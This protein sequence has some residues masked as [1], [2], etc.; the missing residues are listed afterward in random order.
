MSPKVL[1]A[2]SPHVR[3]NYVPPAELDRLNAF[4]NC[5]W[6]SCE[7]G[8]IYDTN[9]DPEAAAQLRQRVADVEALVICHGSPTITAA[10][11]DAAPNLKFIGELEGDRFATRIDLDAAWERGI[12]TVDVTN[13][14]SYPVSEWAL[15]LIL[16]SLRNAGALF[17]QIIEGNTAHR[18]D[19]IRGS[20]KILTGKRIGLIGGG[21]MGAATDSVPAPIRD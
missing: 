21:H 17:R 2:F 9:D 15:A 8:G 6:F 19:D 1:M 10:V 7:G 12:R 4:A 11:M 14:S 16:I 18:W 13:G 3:N 20:V 5:D